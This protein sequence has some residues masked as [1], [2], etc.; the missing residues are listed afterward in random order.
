MFDFFYLSFLFS[1]DDRLAPIGKLTDALNRVRSDEN[2]RIS[3]PVICGK[4]FFSIRNGNYSTALELLLTVDQEDG[5]HLILLF[6]MICYA[7]LHIIQM[8][9]DMTTIGEFEMMNID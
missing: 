2:N 6:K 9:I 7:H 8:T 5:H 4:A 3:A 1:S